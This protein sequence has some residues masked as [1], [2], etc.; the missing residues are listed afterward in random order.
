MDTTGNGGH[1]NA[2]M[3]SASDYLRIGLVLLYP[4]G[5]IVPHFANKESESQAG[6]EMDPNLPSW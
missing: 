1:D 2:A 5:S 4:V 3:C 6:L